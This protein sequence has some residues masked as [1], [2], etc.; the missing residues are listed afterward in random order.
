MIRA[1]RKVKWH[2]KQEAAKA[3]V[4]KRRSKAARAARA[5]EEEAWRAAREREQA[6]I[7]AAA[8]SII[9]RFS[10]EDVAFLADL[11]YDVVLELRLLV[12]EA[13]AAFG[14]RTS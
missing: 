12:A 1:D 11:T 10:Q 4:A 2:A 9:D 7:R 5:A 3:E 6:K 13:S 8:Q 14:Q